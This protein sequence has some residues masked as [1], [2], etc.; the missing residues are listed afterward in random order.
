MSTASRI[1]L[2]ALA[3]VLTACT[4]PRAT[5][6]R[7]TDRELLRYMPPGAT[8]QHRYITDYGVTY[9]ARFVILP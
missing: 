2:L 3:I 6:R 9:R 1:L 5:P 8:I 7:L 4:T